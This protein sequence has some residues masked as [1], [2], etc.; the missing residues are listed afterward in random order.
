[1]NLNFKN[2][3]EQY[4]KY[5]CSFE[6]WEA[7]YTMHVSGF[8]S[9]DLWNKFYDKCHCWTFEIEEFE[10]YYRGVVIDSAG[11]VEIVW[12]MHK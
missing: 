1:M 11:V 10:T 8:I 2:M 12:E 3:V 4:K 7:Y 6:L 5:E 9:E